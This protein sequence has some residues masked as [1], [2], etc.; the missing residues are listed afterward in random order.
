VGAI[1]AKIKIPKNYPKRPDKNFFDH[2]SEVF[3]D[4]NLYQIS[5]KCHH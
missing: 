2:I 3:E 1:V 4:I 5:V